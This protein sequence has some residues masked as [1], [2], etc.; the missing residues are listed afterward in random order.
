MAAVFSRSGAATGAFSLSF[1]LLIAACSA[2]YSH[3]NGGFA[4]AQCDLPVGL[5]RSSQEHVDRL[6]EMLANT[7]ALFR[8]S[9]IP[10]SIDGGTLLGAVRHGGYIPWDDDCDLIVPLDV[11]ERV[12]A[13]QP[14]LAAY[15]MDVVEKSWGLK[16]CD[17]EGQRKRCV[18]SPPYLA[19]YC[20]GLLDPRHICCRT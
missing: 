11:K 13:L 5:V 9:G 16:L 8:A 18:Q 12:L 14:E 1:R 19:V 7:D 15:K 17:S 10:Y 2:P 3:Q 20:E 6:Y 4:A